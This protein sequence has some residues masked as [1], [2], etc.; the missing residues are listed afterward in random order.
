MST[1]VTAP[2]VRALLM[3]VGVD[4]QSLD[5]S[6]A[7]GTYEVNIK[8]DDDNNNSVYVGGDLVDTASAGYRLKAGQTL[9]DIKVSLLGT[10]WIVG[11]AAAQKVY[12]FWTEP[13]FTHD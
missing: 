11:G 9:S 5:P 7:I 12:A 4:R 6:H 8:A 3:T 1:H 2:M 13:R 10:I